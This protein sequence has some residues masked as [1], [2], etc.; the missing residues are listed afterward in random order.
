MTDLAAIYTEYYP[1]VLNLCR[2]MLKSPEDAEDMAQQVFV[3]LAS[4]PRGRCLPRY[5]QFHGRSKF[6]TWLYR[7]TA[8]L[9]LMELRRQRARPLLTS[10]D[11]E[12]NNE[13][14]PRKIEV[15]AAARVDV[16]GRLLL[17]QA[18]GKLAPGYRA[19][20]ILRYVEGMTNDETGAALGYT[21]G[22]S[23][24]QSHRAI[25]RMREELAP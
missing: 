7:V 13:D 1:Y 2:R 5:T 3:Q 23:R 6:R 17:V 15:P 4:V 16:D 22:C 25:R 9:C 11:H 19:V 14:G 10:L 18:L 21:G 12:V 20:L 24:S 8:N